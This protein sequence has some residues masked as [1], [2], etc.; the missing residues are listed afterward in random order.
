MTRR[1]RIKLTSASRYGGNP[2]GDGEPPMLRNQKALFQPRSCLTGQPSMTL[3]TVEISLLNGKALRSWREPSD[4]PAQQVLQLQLTGQD[5]LGRKS[6][7]NRG[8]RREQ[9][10]SLRSPGLANWLG[11]VESKTRQ[12]PYA[13]SSWLGSRQRRS[14]ASE[15]RSKSEACFDP[16][17]RASG[18]GSCAADGEPRRF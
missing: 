4:R 3:L 12:S 13:K 5:P 8:V 9:R 14:A 6:S 18:P 15:Q 7:A 1:I 10:T 17:N 11:R 2:A 16:R